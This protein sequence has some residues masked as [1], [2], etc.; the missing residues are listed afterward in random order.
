M[1]MADLPS[2]AP[3]NPPL[4]IRCVLF[5]LDGT[6]ADTAPDL[7]YALNQILA[8]RGRPS[9]PYDEVRAAASHGGTALIRLGFDLNPED[10]EFEPLRQE[11][12]RIYRDNIRLHTTLFPGIPRL[13]DDLE[14]RGLPWGLVTNKPSWLTNPL[15]LELGLD[16]RPACVVSGDSTPNPKPRPRPILH[17]CELVSVA[18]GSCLYIGDA[19]RD[20]EAGN[21]AGATTLVALFGYIGAKDRPRDWGAQGTIEHPL[22]ILDWLYNDG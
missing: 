13:L 6:F 4:P 14:R 15:L 12:L 8:A 3:A 2:A 19:A 9:P 21:R 5:D 16:G 22:D 11:F 17:A 20:I 10:P 7:A 18:P 1:Q